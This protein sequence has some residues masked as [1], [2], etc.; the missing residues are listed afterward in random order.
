MPKKKIAAVFFLGCLLLGCL[1]VPYVWHKKEILKQ[2]DAKPFFTEIPVAQYTHSNLPCFDI[3]LSGKTLTAILDLGYTRQVSLRSDLVPTILEKQFLKTVPVWGVRGERF[4]QNLYRA[5]AVKIDNLNIAPILL[6]EDLP[7]LHEQAQI[8]KTEEGFIEDGKLGWRLFKNMVLFL[9]FNED[10][11]E[12][13]DSLETFENHNNLADF[14]KVPLILDRELLEF[15]MTTP[16]GPV[17]CFLDTGCTSNH[18]HSS[19]PNNLLLDELYFKSVVQF[20]S[21]N[22]GNK[23]FGP[24]TFHALPLQ[25]PVRI[26]GVLGMEFL[27]STEVFI[28]F[29]NQSIYFK[30]KS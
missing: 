14:V 4:Q 17:R 23:K 1:L 20:P 6:E 3:V 19:N 9:D 21:V 7:E 5:R 30:S 10:K 8:V 16:Q 15:D 28:D 26:Q 22:I 18:L 2:S 12:V 24:I 25:V 13:A 29:K 11:I 27:F